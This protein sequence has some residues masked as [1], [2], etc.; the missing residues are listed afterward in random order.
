M[1]RLLSF[2]YGVINYL[3]FL[4]VFLYAIAFV[5]DFAVPKTIDAGGP[6]AAFW[7]ALLINAALLGVF[8]LQHSVMARPGFKK[9]WTKIVPIATERSTYVLFS[10][11]ALILLFWQWR[12]LP[13]VVWHVEAAMG[14]WALWGL[15]GLGWA[16]VL[17]AT[18]MISHA[19]LFGLKQVY[20]HARGEELSAPDFQIR[21]L[22][23]YVRH[24][25]NLGFIIAFWAT[26]HMTVGHLIF[27]VATTG[28][29]LIATV[30]EERDLVGAFGEK[31]RRY[32]KRVPMIMPRAKRGAALENE[33]VQARSA[34]LEQDRRDPRQA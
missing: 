1:R 25:L 14:Q 29:I 18:F 16:L 15:F 31:Y 12:P 22:Y 5:G 7:P 4:G 32:Q 26:P 17:L 34:H 6:S 8:A 27:A 9:W 13:D 30:L 23:R 33:P 11:L 24:P 3:V 2:L 28:Y 21:G 10:N 19:H 20:E